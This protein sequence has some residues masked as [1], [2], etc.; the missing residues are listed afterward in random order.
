MRYNHRRRTLCKQGNRKKKNCLQWVVKTSKLS[1]LLADT[2]LGDVLLFNVVSCWAHG[3]DCKFHKSLAPTTTKTPKFIM[4]KITDHSKVTLP[5]KVG[6]MAFLD[7]VAPLEV[8][9]NGAANTEKFVRTSKGAELRANRTLHIR[10]DA[11]A[12]NVLDHAPGVESPSISA[13]NRKS[14]KRQIEKMDD[15]VPHVVPHRPIFQ[16]VKSASEEQADI[17]IE[18]IRCMKEG[19]FHRINSSGAVLKSAQEMMD[20]CGQAISKWFR[21]LSGSA[22]EKTIKEAFQKFDTDGSGQIDRVEFA[23]A[24]HLMGLR[25]SKEAYDLL[26]KT[27]DVDRSGEIDLREFTKM[28]HEILGKESSK[29]TTVTPKDTETW[30]SDVQEETKSQKSSETLRGKGVVCL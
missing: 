22:L 20:E 15:A 2:G 19:L 11:H 9:H 14:P 1:P 16:R 3:N 12:G 17:A 7:I 29:D 10:I 21:S 13:G 4:D 23:Q 18:K 24:M 5:Q 30:Y 8:L 27:Y 6:E 26:F 28:V 25:M